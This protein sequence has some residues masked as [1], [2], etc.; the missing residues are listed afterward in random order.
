MSSPMR[1]WIQALRRSR[2]YRVECLPTDGALMTAFIEMHD[3][4]A[5]AELVYRHGQM[6]WSTCRRVLHPDIHA[7]DDALQ[8]VFLILA[9]KA[10]EVSPPDRVGA[11]L[12]GV[13]VHVAQKA[14]KRGERYIPVSPVDLDKVPVM[15]KEADLDLAAF[16][17]VIDEILAGL[18]AK[19]RSPVIL[20]ELEGRSRAHAAQTL[21]WTE[22]TLSGRLARAKKLLAD[23][24]TR[25]GYS[26]P[27]A[28]LTLLLVQPSG[29]SLPASL[30]ASTLRA[31]AILSAGA[32]SSSVV[33][34]LRRE[35]LGDRAAGDDADFQ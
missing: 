25:R 2:D 14:L 24:L 22:G 11:W 4:G 23:R 10:S 9:I 33:T 3:D 26:L 8:A 6:V 32:D 17:K 19:Y 29:T 1:S 12:H 13:A 21:G 28:G 34:G 18:P 31:A 7:A 30:V 5:F 15:T 20:C 27:S 16:R 35:Y